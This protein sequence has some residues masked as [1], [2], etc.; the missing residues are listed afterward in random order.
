[1]AILAVRVVG[2]KPG[3]YPPPGEPDKSCTIKSAESIAF[4]A[5]QKIR[6]QNLYSVHAPTDGIVFRSTTFCAPE[7][8]EQ[9]QPRVPLAALKPTSTPPLGQAP[10]Q[11]GRKRA[12]AGERLVDP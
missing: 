3:R 7:C 8:I 9:H 6:T 1:L 10:H 4:L 11:L 2:I 12:D 5:P